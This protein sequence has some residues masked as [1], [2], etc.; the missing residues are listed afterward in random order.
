MTMFKY[1]YFLGFVATLL[2]TSCTDFDE[3]GKDPK[4]P[5]DVQ[6]NSVFLAGQ[7]NL[8]DVYIT[9]NWSS[10][11]FRVLAQTWTQ[12]SYMNEA[13][14]QFVNNNAPDGWWDKLYSSVLVNLTDAKSRYQDEITLAEGVK[15]NKRLITDI[16]EVYAF[17][18]LVNTYGDIPYTEALNRTI[19]F[20]KYDAA[21]DVTYDLIKR[22]DE[23]IEGLNESEGSFGAADQIYQGDVKQWKK[24]AAVLKLKLALLIADSDEQTAL[25]KVNEA[26]NAG[27]FTSNADN[28]SF[29]Y[30]AGV[31]ENANPVWQQIVNGTSAIYYGTSSFFVNTLKKLNDPRLPILFTKDAEGGYSGAVPGQGADN[32][33]LSQYT[34]FWLS[35][36]VPAVLLSYSETLFLLSEA[37]ARGFL[38]QSAADYYHEAIK[39]AIVEFGGTVSVAEA[40]IL[41]PSVAYTTAEGDWRQ[42]IGTQKWLAFANRNWDSWTEIRRLGHPNLDVL[43]PPVNAISQLPKRFYY[44]IKEQNSNT[45]HWQEAVKSIG[46]EDVVTAKLFWQR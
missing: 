34:D 39:N 21:K 23:S 33:K 4:S 25:Q 31:V 45:A 19:P 17:S 38:S 46:G 30:K 37:S 35:A 10:S 22:L 6:P 3:L 18:L 2:L 7:K 24:F 40:Y 11:P 12:T 14:Y 28:A 16:L 32:T 5:V 36:E 26:I 41:Q 15:T 27:L 1:I 13:Q 20:P 9:S 29:R 8:A 42:K 44:P 43:S